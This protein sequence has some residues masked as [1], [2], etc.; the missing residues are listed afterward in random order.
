MPN[1]YFG[2]LLFSYV[3]TIIFVCLGYLSCDWKRVIMS[4]R[5]FS[6]LCFHNVTAAFAFDISIYSIAAVGHQLFLFTYAGQVLH[7]HKGLTHT[8]SL[9]CGFDSSVRRALHWYRRGRGF[10]SHSKPE[11]F[12]GLCFSSV[13]AA[14]A[15]DISID[16]KSS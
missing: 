2:S 10:K 6:G 1:Q 7:S 4:N 3:D 15:F 8:R 9:P 12:S 11:F 13:T 14:F 16:W 5:S